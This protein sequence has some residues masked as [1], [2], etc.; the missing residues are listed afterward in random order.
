MVQFCPK[1]GAPDPDDQAVFCH[2]C[3]NRLP[4]PVPEITEITC[5]RCGTKI[6]DLQAVFC[7]KCGSPVHTPPPVQVR[8]GGARPAAPPDMKPERCPSCGAPHVDA[9]SDYCN[10]CGAPL[11]GSVP[12]STVGARPAAVPPATKPERCPSC[13]APHVDATSD[14]CNVCGAPLRRSASLGT[15]GETHQP[16]PEKPAPV[17]VGPARE[18]LQHSP[19]KP[20]PAHPV[21]ERPDTGTE[22]PPPEK[23]RRPL[24]KWGLMAGVAVIVLIIIGASMSG[25]IPGFNTSSNAT[26]APGDQNVG[27]ALPAPTGTQATMPVPTP[28]PSKA[29]A[30]TVPTT[31]VPANATIPVTTKTTTPVPMNTTPNAT[32]NASAVKTT[33]PVTNP[34]QPLSVGQS[35]YDGKGKLTV[36]G[37]SYKDKMSDP[38]PSYAIGKQY[39]IVNITYENLQ[40]ETMD[41]D[42]S[43]MRITDGGGYA[44][45][46]VSDSLL[47]NAYRGQSIA[48]QEKRTGNLLFIVPPGATFLKLEYGSPNEKRATFRLT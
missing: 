9:I 29:P 11:H 34:S 40:N 42:L 46:P 1:C 20:A 8:H 47:E 19:E 33:Q 26:P 31:V 32:A 43:M 4:P 37:F 36:S 44:F 22:Y 38:T 15:T 12:L 28:S 5:P 3:G 24:L 16:Y 17:P 13:G 10:V 18:S 14:Y 21:A 41:V 45:D 30:T 25:M 6:P 2:A 23:S 39:L 27:T 48:P 35:A 7:N